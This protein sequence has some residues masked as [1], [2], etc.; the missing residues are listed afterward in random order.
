MQT[1]D[2]D[3]VIIGG[4]FS[5]LLIAYLLQKKGVMSTILEAR[6]RLGGR[7]YTLRSNDAPPIEMG[8]TWLGKKHHHLL[9]LLDKLDI[10]ICEQYMG[11][12]GYYEPMSVTPPQLVD[13]PPNEEPSCR[14]TGGTNNIIKV[15]ADRLEENQIHLDQAVKTIR[16]TDTTLE[17]QT[18]SDLIK[19]DFAIST[20][21][22]KLLADSIDCSPSLP[23]ELTDIASQ[24]HT[25][26]AESIKVALTFEEPFW[27]HSDSSGTIFS[28]VGPVSEM[29]DHSTNKHYAL[30][31]FMNNTYQAATRERRKKLVIEQLRR[32]YGEKADSYGAYR[33]LV[34]EDE[35]FSYSHYEQPIFPHQ[36]NGHPIFQEPFLNNRLLISGSE[37][38]TEFP[39]YMD[40][41]VES[42]QR[43][44][45]QLKQLLSR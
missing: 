43:T 22:P 21:P 20:L 32:F 42:A 10:D 31:G 4:G 24:T 28:N 33:E 9:D 17:I 38:A 8:A 16:K 3:I 30:K 34:W 40:G 12:K 39:G 14:I 11:S 45:R 18:D 5:G 36:H 27:R 19:A 23:D 13:L 15:L 2:P 44:V 37:T 6:S 26:M 41:A 1:S 35:P 7:I 29:Y 25:W